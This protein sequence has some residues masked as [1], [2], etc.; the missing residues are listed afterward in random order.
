MRCNPM[1]RFPCGIL[2]LFIMPLFLGC[3]TTQELTEPSALEMDT[4]AVMP[5]SAELPRQDAGP[6][7]VLA[8]FDA[9][10]QRHDLAQ[11]REVFCESFRSVLAEWER[12][13]GR[14][15]VLELFAQ[16]TIGRRCAPGYTL[17]AR[18]G[19]NAALWLSE[20]DNWPKAHTAYRSASENPAVRDIE[21][22]YCGLDWR[23][24][25]GAWRLIRW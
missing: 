24:E 20:F 12:Q 4:P 23:L 2:P 7:P 3:A 11:V 13:L 16:S 18:N 10:I 21:I 17:V 9:A 25:S 6:A 8:Q 19:Q 22:R 5:P 1:T 14:Q 15:A